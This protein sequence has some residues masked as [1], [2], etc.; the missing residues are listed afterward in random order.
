MLGC[1]AQEEVVVVTL[2]DYN[3]RKEFCKE[4]N[5]REEAAAFV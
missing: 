1:S 2:L 5:I 4:V 3:V